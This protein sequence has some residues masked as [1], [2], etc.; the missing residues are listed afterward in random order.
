MKINCGPTPE[1]RYAARKAKQEA[2]KQW[3]SYFAWLPRRVGSGDCRWLEYVERRRVGHTE[4]AMTFTGGVHCIGSRW[5][6]R[7]IEEQA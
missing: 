6:Y 7:A 3:H 5:E 1:E 4:I 2:W